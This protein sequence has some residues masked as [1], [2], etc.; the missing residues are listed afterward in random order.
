MAVDTLY[1]QDNTLC[2]QPP[3]AYEYVLLVNTSHE[4][5]IIAAETAP[6]YIQVVSPVHPNNQT[7][8]SRYSLAEC[9]VRP[10]FIS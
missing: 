8:N 10:F 5:N 2:D 1:S 9:I 4:G 3:S 7:S 6:D